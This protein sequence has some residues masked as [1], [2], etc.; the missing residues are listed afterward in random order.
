[1]IHDSTLQLHKYFPLYCVHVKLKKNRTKHFNLLV[2]GEIL[3]F[4]SCCTRAMTHA[5]ISNSLASNAGGT[6]H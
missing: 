1:M 5:T 2:K 3:F 4:H 6:M